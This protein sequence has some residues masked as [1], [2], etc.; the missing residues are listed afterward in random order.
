ML[1]DW[2][3]IEIP[4]RNKA[5]RTLGVALLSDEDAHLAGYG[6]YL[7]PN[8]YVRRDIYAPSRSWRRMHREVMGLAT[9][10]PR[11]VDHINRNRLDNRR[12]NLRILSQSGN[13][14][15]TSGSSKS[16]LRGVYLDP[17]N[18]RWY[19]QVKFQGIKHHLGRFDTAEAAAEAARAE[20][21]RLMPYSTED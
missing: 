8:G 4:L 17:R 1:V 13:V 2:T 3:M 9:G 19:A 11:Q 15:N 16:G 20:R 5:R 10:D 18:G 6:W 12:S 7:E 14:Q 21:V